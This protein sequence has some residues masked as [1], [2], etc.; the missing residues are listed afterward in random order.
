[1]N[2]F[3]KKF[4]WT[5]ERVKNVNVLFQYEREYIERLGELANAI[6]SRGVGNSL[7]LKRKLNLLIH[8]YS[9]IRAIL[10]EL[11]MRK[12]LI[13]YYECIEASINTCSEYENLLD[14]FLDD[15]EE[16]IE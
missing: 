14:R 3:S 4:G 11:K 5:P 13:Y 12:R 15:E 1:M 9:Y 7:F 6:S 8:F 10:D 16:E 2:Y